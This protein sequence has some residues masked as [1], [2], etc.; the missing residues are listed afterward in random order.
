MEN[1]AGAY[2]VPGRLQGGVCGG[3][4]AVAFAITLTKEGNHMDGA[5]VL[6]ASIGGLAHGKDA[7]I[8]TR[9]AFS[10]RKDRCI[11]SR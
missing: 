10:R 3:R 9:L 7:S 6:A 1:I 11:F 4:K 5:V 2:L 8:E